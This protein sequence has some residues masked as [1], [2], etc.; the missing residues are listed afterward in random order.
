MKIRIKGNSIRFRLSKSEVDAFGAS[1]YCESSTQ[2]TDN[3][4]TYSLVAVHDQTE[5]K[6]SFDA[7][8]IQVLMPQHW[9]DEWVAT[10]RVGFESQMPLDSEKSLQILIEKDFQCLDDRGEDE[11]DMY[12]NPLAQK[13]S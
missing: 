6:A 8:G 3:T 12:P 4:F 11:S 9:A 13:E 5:L 7:K 2:F 1:G 10:Q